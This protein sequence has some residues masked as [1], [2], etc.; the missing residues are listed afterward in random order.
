MSR[1]SFSPMVLLLSVRLAIGRLVAPNLMIV[2][3]NMP[4]HPKEQFGAI[5]RE[6][7]VLHQQDGIIFSSALP[8]AGGV[9]TPCRGRQTAQC[10]AI[11]AHYLRVLPATNPSE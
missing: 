11:R 6:S 5:Q 7:I 9:K 8:A 1:T 3:G 2:G 10:L 4:F